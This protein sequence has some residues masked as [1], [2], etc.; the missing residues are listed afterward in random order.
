M[1][2]SLTDT[3]DMSATSS[4]IVALCRESE[5]LLLRRFDG[6]R[7]YPAGVWCFPGGKVDTGES[8][9]DA[10]RREVWEETGL[11][12]EVLH[13]VGTQAVTSPHG[14]EFE[15][16]C[17]VCTKWTGSLLTFPSEEHV[18]GRWVR[19][20]LVQGM[21]IAG[22]ATAWLAEHVSRRIDNRRDGPPDDDGRSPAEP[23]GPCIGPRSDDSGSAASPGIAG[24]S[25]GGHQSTVGY[26]QTALATRPSRSCTAPRASAP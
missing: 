14:R 3:Y 4:A 10:A 26:P 6:D 24:A 16:A 1:S 22:P 20:D 12:P 25:A 15:I 18:E 21:R 19:T 17:Y 7:T 9:E 13:R 8:I 11:V 2:A 5:V 23:A